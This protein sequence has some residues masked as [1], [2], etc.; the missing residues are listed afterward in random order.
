[1][2]Y[3]F[4]MQLSLTIESESSQVGLGVEANLKTT[5]I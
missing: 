1:V 5:A 2:V 4:V 3:S